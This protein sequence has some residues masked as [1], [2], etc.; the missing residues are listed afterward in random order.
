MDVRYHQGSPLDHLHQLN[1]QL[2][3]EDEL[4]LETLILEGNDNQVLLL[5]DRYVTMRNIFFIPSAR[6][7]KNWL[8]KCGFVDVK[9]VDICVTSNQEQR[10]S[11]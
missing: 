3:S 5:E 9:I 7:L 4:I 1:T 6:L 8:E 2:I 10:R 11:S